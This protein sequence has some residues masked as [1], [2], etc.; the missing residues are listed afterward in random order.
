MKDYVCQVAAV[1][2]GLLISC[3]FSV[4]LGL[5]LRAYTSWQTKPSGANKASIKHCS[6]SCVNH[7]R[8]HEGT[9]GNK[10]EQDHRD[11]A[12]MLGTK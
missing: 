9:R 1:L 5:K 7:I 11:D 10:T 2:D 6:P 8:H 3:H 12:N 4:V